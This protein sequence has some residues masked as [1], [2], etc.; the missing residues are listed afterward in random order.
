MGR[1]PSI[2][3]PF[4]IT[5]PDAVAAS[6]A[7]AM[8]PSDTA[9]R[10]ATVRTTATDRRALLATDG[11]LRVGT[12]TPLS[13]CSGRWRPGPCSNSFW[14]ARCTM[15]GLVRSRVVLRPTRCV[16]APHCAWPTGPAEI[17]SSRTRMRLGGAG[18]GV[19]TRDIQLGR[20]ALCQLSYSRPEREKN[21]PRVTVGPDD[22]RL[23]SPCAGAGRP[24]PVGAC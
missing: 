22:R 24:L 13:G 1:T 6:A 23:R 11:K 5:A 2:T 10:P 9:N 17:L 3:V 14:S 16:N 15:Y 8:G 18:D 4:E 21:L 20:L 12:R 19:R 7:G